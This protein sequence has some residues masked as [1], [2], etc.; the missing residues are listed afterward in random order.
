MQDPDSMLI[1]SGNILADT[2]KYDVLPA[3]GAPCDSVKLTHEFDHHRGC[4][5][6]E[7]DVYRVNGG[8]SALH[9]K[10]VLTTLGQAVQSRRPSLWGCT[11]GSVGHVPIHADVLS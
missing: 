1:S 6:E 8:A 4:G 11:M 7:Q 5:Q 9:L 3:L 2:L 10:S